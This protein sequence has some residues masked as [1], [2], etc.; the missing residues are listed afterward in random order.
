MITLF[1]FALVGV[2]AIVSLSDWRK[3]L[4]LMILVGLL[5]D[6]VRKIMP[7]AP[8]Y[9]VLA[10]TPIWLVVGASVLFSGGQAWSRFLGTFPQLGVSIRFLGYSLLLAFL[11]L[12]IKHG[13]D[14][15]PIGVIGLVGYLFPL[16]AMAVGFYFARR[17]AD[18]VRLMTFYSALT[19]VALIGGPLQYWNLF[20]DWTALGTEAL[21]T[22]WVRQYHGHAVYMVSGFFRSPDLMGW[23][24]AVLVMFSMIMSFRTSNPVFKVLWILLIAWGATNLL[25]SGRNKMI[26]MP[27][28]F[29][30]VVTFLNIYKG[31]VGHSMRVA[32]VGVVSVGLLLAINFQLSLD[33]EFLLY[34]KKGSEDATERLAVGGMYSVWSTYQ[35]SG[36]FGEGLGSAST[37]ARHGGRGGIG[38]WQESG[39][40][41]IMVELGAIGFIALIAL[42]FAL[43]QT[44]QRQ[45]ARIPT[46]APDTQLYIAFIGILAAN[47]A[48][49]VVSHQA[50]GD[51]FL[52]TLVGL[53][54]GCLLAGPRWQVRSARVKKRPDGQ[55]G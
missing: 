34:T 39:P 3:G 23:H 1:F 7:G 11:V 2:A 17:P 40:S 6:P 51:P 18:L 10:F 15:V 14:K 38:T 28:V 36:F 43:L 30:C 31:S 41:K 9:M 29:L 16:L 19:A 22:L 47:A 27:A 37:G 20:P 54:L 48:S 4:L 12:L 21:G 32:L 8:V 33:E 5:Q 44:L 25:I 50:F 35:Q 24:A 55:H 45:F 46:G 26:F 49:F 53:F 42:A 13:F 52:V